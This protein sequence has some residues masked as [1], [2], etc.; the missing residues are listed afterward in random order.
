ML[1][2]FCSLSLSVSVCLSVC[3]VCLSVCL[4]YL[5]CLSVLSVC[6]SCLSACLSV[7]VLSACLPVCLELPCPSTLANQGTLQGVAQRCLGN[8]VSSRK[9]LCT[10]NYSLADIIM[11]TYGYSGLHITEESLSKKRPPMAA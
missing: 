1:V 10:R 11:V 7:S 3:F 8:T 4:V 6:L 2:V 5:S 9:L